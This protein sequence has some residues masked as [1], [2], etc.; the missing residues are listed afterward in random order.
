MKTLIQLLLTFL[1]NASWQIIL[2]ATAAALCGWL[3]RDTAARY[4]HALWICA[5][6]L[7][8]GIPA[9]SFVYLVRPPSIGKQTP[10]DIPPVPI[11]VSTIISTDVKPMDSPVPENPVRIETLKP[12]LWASPVRVNPR[13]AAALVTFYALFLLYRGGNFF[14]A[15]RRTRAIVAGAREFQ[16]LAPFRLIV[17][18]CQ[19]SVGVSRVRILCSA[20]VPVPITVGI[21]N[22]LII[23]PERL[24]H[25]IDHG[26]LTSAIGHELVHIARRDYLSNLIYELIYLPLSFHPAAALIRR[27][28]KQTREL[29]CDEAVAAKLLRPEIYARSL[30]RLIGSV[31][32]PRRLTA[33]TTIGITE[34]DNLEVRIMTLIKR[35]KPT[36]RL[37]RLLLIAV[38]A[39]LITPCIA[40][41][42][43][44]LRLDLP[45]QE[46]STAAQKQRKERLERE[47]QQ[48]ASEE[49]K[50]AANELREKL[51]VAQETERP[52]LQEKLKEVERALEEHARVVQKFELEWQEQNEA[53][54][55][56]LR[57]ALAQMEK[58][59]PRD[60]ARISKMRELIAE[61]E[62]QRT[63]QMR[64]IEQKVAQM[65][66]QYSENLEA[67]L[68]AQWEIQQQKEKLQGE[69]EKEQLKYKE[70]LEKEGEGYRELELKRRQE[71]E[72]Q[73]KN[74]EYQAREET[75]QGAELAKLA[76]ISMDRAIQ[77]ATSQNPGKVL[78]CSLSRNKEGQVFY[79]LVIINTDGDRNTLKFVWVSA[80]DGTILKSTDGVMKAISGGV[81][82][83]RAITLPSP[84]YPQIARA[85]HAAGQ[86]S[87]EVTIDEQG[88]VIEAT[89]VSGHPLLQGAS[90]SAAREAKF[91]PTYMEG[92]P[93]KVTGLITYNF[94]A[95]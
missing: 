45:P 77:I 57:E 15:W 24:L 54:L 62:K 7:S 9:L 16:F 32:I 47:N 33:D 34:S 67:T 28:I 42:K 73:G 85:A 83:G 31:P 91:S 82:N 68:R 95:Q 21:I 84:K 19:K 49:L 12:G 27:R 72:Y 6:L 25:E 55:R 61:I 40:A 13:L 79:R 1:V 20:S 88:N 64:E 35:T 41:A 11:V 14:R 22:P 70:L 65:R 89:A 17:K 4:R 60:D 52:Q 90:V 93:V 63:E 78:S 50:R 43:L 76:N 5:L 30:V 48:R 10:R 53:K 69:Y 81:L 2:I 3:L 75:A 46:P 71:F 8:L 23:L 86:V 66:T 58:S 38:S 74:F 39:L 56:E 26:V 44:A 37:K 94:V 18:R 92:R 36:A 59:Q 29:C 80:I 51:R 87:V